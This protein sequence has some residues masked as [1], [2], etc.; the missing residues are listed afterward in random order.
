MGKFQ[1][2]AISSV[3]SGTD[4][5]Q[6]KCEWGRPRVLEPSSC[7]NALFACICGTFRGYIVDWW[8]KARDA[9]KYSQA[10]QMRRPSTLPVEAF[11]RANHHP[12]IN[13]KYNSN[14]ITKLW[15]STLTHDHSLPAHGHIGHPSKVKQA[16]T[17]LSIVRWNRDTS[18]S[19]VPLAYYR[20]AGT[21]LSI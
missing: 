17:L 11:C 2:Q 16:C 4:A 8:G 7:Y 10:S 20:A 18:R 21:V 12:D 19:I 1:L 13:R 6:T 5:L 14:H 3:F 15:T 9:W